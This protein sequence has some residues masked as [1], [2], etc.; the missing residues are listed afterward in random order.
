M[1]KQFL[2]EA[3]ESNKA[4]IGSHLLRQTSFFDRSGLA[5]EACLSHKIGEAATLAACIR[6]QT[7]T[8]LS[9]CE[10]ASPVFMGV[11]DFPQ[12]DLSIS[13]L[14]VELM[15]RERNAKRFVFDGSKIT[16]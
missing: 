15:Q 9:S 13:L 7:A 16:A 12:M 1:L 4:A 3:I 6:C 2:P 8:A 10:V 14:P 5:N 11:S